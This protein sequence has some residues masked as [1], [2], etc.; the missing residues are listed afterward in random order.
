MPSR[1]V[2]PLSKLSPA[3]P[4]FLMQRR[5]RRADPHHHPDHRCHRHPRLLAG[6]DPRC[7]P[8]KS[9]WLRGALAAAAGH[10]GWG[11]CSGTKPPTTVC[12]SPRMQVQGVVYQRPLEFAEQVLTFLDSAQVGAAML[13]LPL[14]TPA[15]AAASTAA[16]ALPST[17]LT[18]KP[19]HA[20]QLVL[21]EM[22]PNEQF[23][24]YGTSAATPA[25]QA[26]VASLCAAV[27]AVALLALA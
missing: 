1:Q 26:A 24:F 25:V 6:A 14:S 16:A 17:P 9:C 5:S 23:T 20:P 19:G 13:P 8:R 2:L 12:L 4:V 21:Q 10:V 7:R 27:A 15:P 3:P 22:Q 11:A 18:E